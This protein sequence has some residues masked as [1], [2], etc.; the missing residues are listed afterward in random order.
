MKWTDINETKYSLRSIAKNNVKVP[1]KPRSKCMSFS[2]NGARL[3]NM[4]PSY[5]WETSRPSDFKT[6]TKEWVWKNIPSY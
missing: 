5:I 4:L 3:M 6:L 2:Y 1:M